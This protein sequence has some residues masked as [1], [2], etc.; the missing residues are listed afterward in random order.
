MHHDTDRIVLQKV[1]GDLL[2]HTFQALTAENPVSASQMRFELILRKLELLAF[3]IQHSQLMRRCL[4][5]VQFRGDQP[6]D[7][8]GCHP[9]IIQGVL[10]HT[11]RY[12]AW[13]RSGVEG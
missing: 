12:T 7:L 1:S 5:R 9:W 13:T 6:I 11:D 10:D 4:D 3:G 8:Q 2:L